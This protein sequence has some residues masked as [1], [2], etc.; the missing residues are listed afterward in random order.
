MMRAEPGDG[1]LALRSSEGT[2]V[3]FHLA[4]LSE[5]ASAFAIDFTLTTAATTLVAV[6]AAAL[7]ASGSRPIGGAIFLAGSFFFRNV[8]FTAAELFGSGQTWGK[9]KLHIRA[10]SRDGGPL[11]GE[12]ILARN[13]TRELEFFLPLAA[14]TQPRGIL[15]VDE[16]WGVVIAGCWFAVFALFPILNRERLRCGDLLGGTV[17]VRVPEPALLAEAAPLRDDVYAFTPAQLSVYGIAELQVLEDIVRRP[18][19]R[20][21]APL[22]REVSK[23]IR[24]RIGWSTSGALDDRAFLAAFY[25]AQRSHLE[26]KMLLGVRKESKHD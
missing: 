9:R 12:A 4:S 23:R 6:V 24:R 18:A 13:L 25:E 17:V 22:V 14:L 7:A 2:T 11:T 20:E 5:R 3:R 1:I 8:Y 10:I 21:G 26:H 15:D 19:D 16:R